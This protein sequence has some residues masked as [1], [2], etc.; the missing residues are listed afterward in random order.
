[1]PSALYPPLK[2]AV[3][4]TANAADETKALGIDVSRTLEETQIEKTRI[5]AAQ[6]WQIENREAIDWHNALSEHMGGTLQ[7]LLNSDDHAV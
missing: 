5:V 4:L 6:R 1:M 2:K 7:E 3:K